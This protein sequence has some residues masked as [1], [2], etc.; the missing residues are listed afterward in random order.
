VERGLG[1][2]CDEEALR[3]VNKFP[4]FSPGKQNGSPVRVQM[5]MPINFRLND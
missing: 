5:L 1:Y 2:R 4:K 3:V